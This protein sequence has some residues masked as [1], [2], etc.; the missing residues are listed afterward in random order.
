MA[1][2]ALDT[3]LEDEEELE[4]PPIIELGDGLIEM[5][6]TD[7]GFDDD[8]DQEPQLREFDDNLAEDMEKSELLKIGGDLAVKFQTDRH[9][10]DEWQEVYEKGLES[11]RP[12]ESGGDSARSSRSSRNMSTVV[13]PLIAETATQFQAKAINELYPAQGPVGAI[14]FGEATTELQDQANRVAT[15]MNYQI[16]E[17]MEEYFPDMDQML[18]HLPLVGHTFKKSY[19]DTV[20]RRITSSFVQ[21]A[22]LVVDSDATSLETALRT[23]ETLRM[24]TQKY[25]EYVHTGFYLEVENSGGRSHSSEIGTIPQKVEGVTPADSSE[26]DE[27][28]VLLECHCYLDIDSKDNEPDKPF[29]VTYLEDTEEVVSIRRNWQENS[30]NEFKKETW[31]I[32]YKFLPGLGFYG[33]GLYHII[34]GL[35]K[36]ATGALRSLLDAASFANLQGGFKLKGRVGGGEIEIAPGEFTD[37]DAITEDINKAIMPLPFKEPSQTMMA[38][39]QYVVEVGRRF[40]NTAD[41]NIS[42]ANQNTPV[43][44]TLALLEENGK[45]FSAIHKRLHNAQRK[46]FKLIAKLN[47]MYLPAHYPFRMKG[48]AD[49]YIL[50][51]DF[52]EQIDVVPTSDPS[53]FSSTQRI[54]QGQAAMQMLQAAPEM[55]NKYKVHKRMYEALRI[56]NYEEFLFDPNDIDRMDPVTEN[57]AIM[58]GAPVRAFIDQ[59]HDSHITVLDDWYQ[60][61]PPEGQQMFQNQYISHRSEHMSLLYR[62]QVEAAMGAPL[63]RLPN[64]KDPSDKPDDIDPITDAKIAEAAAHVVNNLKDKQPIGP[65]LP[66]MGGQNAAP[67]PMETA[68][69]MMQIETES[70]QAKTKADIEGRMQKAQMDMQIKQANAQMDLQIEKIKADVKAQEALIKAQSQGQTDQ[71]KV[72]AEIQLAQVKAESEIQIAREKAAAYLQA[73]MA[74][75]NS[76]IESERLRAEEAREIKRSEAQVRIQLDD[77]SRQAKDRYTVEDSFNG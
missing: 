36:A 42:D 76:Q 15:Y 65:A 1:D 62:V 53:T 16:T 4:T 59:H 35:A 73:E 37:I 33:F 47:G 72:A 28:I 66:K 3:E 17:E 2:Y 77:R 18:F 57:V 22:D 7:E 52:D 26:E 60:R 12:D 31:Y 69:M 14:V 30:S 50:A 21:G 68:R 64:F 5:D 63:P 10:R 27:G 39:L 6:L 49:N 51:K 40:A 46:E 38:L 20:L 19:F 41:V 32:S 58:N 55:H 34:G 48:V 45:V 29:I 43:G 70:I 11:L 75:V 23:T 54:A 71:A 44:T 13:H 61:L 24:S 8:E 56:P 67:D 74:R 9:A 25:S